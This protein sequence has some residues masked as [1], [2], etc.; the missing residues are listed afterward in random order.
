MLYSK[1][2][3]MQ[4]MALKESVVNGKYPESGPFGGRAVYR[5][6]MKTGPEPC[7]GYHAGHLLDDG[8]RNPEH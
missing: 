3:E 2:A 1:L 8:N 5:R 4:L 6:L 7:Q